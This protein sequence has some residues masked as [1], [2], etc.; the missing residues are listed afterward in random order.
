MFENQW[1]FI[2][3]AQL[4]SLTGFRVGVGLGALVK[5]S[6]TDDGKMRVHGYITLNAAGG[7]V[8]QAFEA[9]SEGRGKF[10][11]QEFLTRDDCLKDWIDEGLL[12]RL[13]PYKQRIE[14]PCYEGT[15]FAE[16]FGDPGIYDGIVTV[17][18]RASDGGEVQCSI[19]E[20][21]TDKENIY[22]DCHGQL[23]VGVWDYQDEFD[24]DDETASFVVNKETD[25]A[26]FLN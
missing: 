3:K 7:Y 19:T 17:Y 10:L 16:F 15:L 25:Q 4:E 22:D 23:R 12:D 14:F 24:S 18:K 26:V 5:D 21:I 6:L 9:T 2:D 8:Y 13:D 11:G 1:V 20:T